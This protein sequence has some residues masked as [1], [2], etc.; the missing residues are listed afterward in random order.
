MP[1]SLNGLNTGPTIPSP[2]IVPPPP[3]LP[4][5]FVRRFPELAAWDFEWQKWA[6]SF[7]VRLQQGNPLT[8]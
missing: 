2:E 7:N 6:K 4:D 3:R 1:D 5:A 8:F